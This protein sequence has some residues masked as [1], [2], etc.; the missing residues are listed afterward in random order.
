M[1]SPLPDSIGLCGKQAF[2]PI[3]VRRTIAKKLVT[4]FL[5]DISIFVNE[6]RL[7]LR[8]SD[9]ARAA[10]ARELGNG[11]YLIL[12]GVNFRMTDSIVQGF[13]LI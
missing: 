2:T 13:A 4:L 12:L 3:N 7:L 8:Q 9:R 6:C 11:G 5:C 10:S 1:F